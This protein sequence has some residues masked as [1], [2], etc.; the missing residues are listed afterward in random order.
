MI[1]NLQ[2]WAQSFPGWLQWLAIFL[3]AAIPF[4][5]SY[6]GTFVGIAIGL[7]PVV[8]AS[9]A[10]AGNIAAVLAVVAVAGR[11]RR[12]VRTT[13]EPPRS[14]GRQRLRRL[15]ERFGIPGVALLGHPTQLSSAA[16]VG[17]G[18]DRRKVVIWE[19]ASIALWGTVIAVLAGLG[20]DVLLH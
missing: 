12:R 9:A 4:V 11:I 10:I 20:I 1:E 8:A 13:E 7:H 3:I 16:M 19:L 2:A 18:A 17:F 15:F 5:E 14:K 6:S